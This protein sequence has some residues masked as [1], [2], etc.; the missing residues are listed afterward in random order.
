MSTSNSTGAGL[1]KPQIV[2]LGT[3]YYDPDDTNHA[4]VNG[5]EFALPNYKGLPIH[6][7][8]VISEGTSQSVMVKSFYANNVLYR[9]FDATPTEWSDIVS[10]KDAGISCCSFTSS[11]HVNSAGIAIPGPQLN[12]HGLATV[13]F[14]YEDHKFSHKFLVVEN[15]FPQ[16]AYKE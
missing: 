11:R 3:V 12:V 5:I 15:I 16:E 14:A 9:A 4:G 10:L 6:F 8:A 1:L 13:P 7:K 2:T